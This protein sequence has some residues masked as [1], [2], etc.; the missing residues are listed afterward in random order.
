MTEAKIPAKKVHGEMLVGISAVVIGVCALAVSLYETSLMREEQRAAVMPLLELSRSYNL[1]EAEGKS[2]LYLQAQNVG[3]GP[4]K[5]VDFKVTVDGQAQPTW[6][7]A[8]R[9]LT[10]TG[11][12]VSY[13]QSTINGR[14]IPAD[15]MVTMMNLNSTEQIDEI[16]EEFERLDFEA[17]YCSIFDECWTTSFSAFGA[18]TEVQACTRSDDSFSE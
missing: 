18:A 1:S 2:R 6:D 13:G 14:T 12:R 9:A 16:M 7:A 11:E 10:G 4:A 15:R 8:I 17:C 5:V 3:I